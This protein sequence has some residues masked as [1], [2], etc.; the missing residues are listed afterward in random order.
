MPIRLPNFTHELLNACF[1]SKEQRKEIL[2]RLE[3]TLDIEYGSELM[4]RISHSII[5]LILE[6][7]D[8]DFID[9]AFKMAEIDWRDLLVAAG[10]DQVDS[11]KLWAEKILKQQPKVKIVKQLVKQVVPDTE[12][13]IKCPNCNFRFKLSD[14]NAWDGE[15]HKR[16]MQLLTIN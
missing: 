10:H 3:S 5:R 15:R 7:G 4:D 16:C 12:G 2:R 6:N 14:A 13:W 11:H 9:A 1:S 8:K